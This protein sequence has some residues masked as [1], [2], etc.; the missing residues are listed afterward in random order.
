MTMA[1][2]RLHVRD[3]SGAAR[4]VVN[5]SRPAERAWETV[6]DLAPDED[7]VSGADYRSLTKQLKAVGDQAPATPLFGSSP[8]PGSGMLRCANPAMA[9]GTKP[10]CRIME[11]WKLLVIAKLGMQTSHCASG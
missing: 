4:K 9:S 10:E 8:E 11:E 5:P 1:T 2:S 3:Y 7:A 6:D